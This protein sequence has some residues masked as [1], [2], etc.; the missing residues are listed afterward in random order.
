MAAA[1]SEGGPVIPAPPL[2]SVVVKPPFQV[3]HDGTVFGP[4]EIAQVP[5]DVAAHWVTRGWAVN[6]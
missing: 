5:E 3:C 6:K 4:N 2:V 1:K